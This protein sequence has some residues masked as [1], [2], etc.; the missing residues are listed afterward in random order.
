MPEKGRA[1]RVLIVEDEERLGRMVRQ[2]LVE[3]GYP[4]TLATTSAAADDALAESAFDV[5]VLD[6][7]L[8]DGDGLEL[9]QSWREAKFNEPVLILSARD[10]LDDRL[11]GLNLGAD[12]YLS[13]PFSMDELI[14][15]LRAL[16]RRQAVSKQS[17]LEHRMLRLDLLGRV[18]QVRGQTLDLTGREFALLEVFMRNAG[19]VLTRSMISEKIWSEGYDIGNNLLDVYMSRLRHKLETAAAEPLFKTLRGIGYQLI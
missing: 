8:P 19:R 14:A 18:V 10:S 16:A 12:D 15:R 1:M 11:K 9:I 3:L 2:S 13:K 17:V 6:L 7:N 5:V 4:T